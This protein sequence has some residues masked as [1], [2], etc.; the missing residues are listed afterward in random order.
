MVL[1]AFPRSRAVTYWRG[2]WATYRGGSASALHRLPYS[3][4]GFLSRAPVSDFTKSSTQFRRHPAARSFVG[5]GLTLSRRCPRARRGALVAKPTRDRLPDVLRALNIG[6][7]A[8]WVAVCVLVAAVFLGPAALGATAFADCH[9]SCPCDEAPSQVDRYAKR[10][11]AEADDC[12][13]SATTSKQAAGGSSARS[14]RANEDHEDSAPDECPE[15][16]PGC[17]LGLSFALVMNPPLLASVVLLTSETCSVA[18]RDMPGA[19]TCTGIYR[20]PRQLS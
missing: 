8:R 20:P 12:C 4:P 7:R 2:H 18:P 5:Q 19:G 14:S 9:M 10:T 3:R 6:C 17:D 15:D 11:S 1:S 16:C 13:P